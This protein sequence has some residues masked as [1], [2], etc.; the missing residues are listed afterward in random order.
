MTTLTSAAVTK[1]G[2]AH[3]GTLDSM[4]SSSD[5]TSRVNRPRDS[6]LRR[7]ISP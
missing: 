7:P 3:I 6:K 5:A 4:L 1:A 2:H